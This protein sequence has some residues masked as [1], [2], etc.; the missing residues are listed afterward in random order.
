M[1]FACSLGGPPDFLG[2]AG[3]GFGAAA[4]NSGGVSCTSG[5]FT[6][7]QPAGGVAYGSAVLLP[8]I[9]GSGGGGGGGGTA[10]GGSGGGGGGGALLIAASGTLTVN[11]SILANGGAG[12]AVSGSNV[13]A[14]GGGGAGGGIRLVATTIAGNGTISAAGGAGGSASAASPPPFLA[15]AG[16]QGRVR[17][18][19][20]TMTRT[21]AT[22]P[23]F[24]FDAPGTVFVAGFPA[25]T[26]T[27]VAG[28]AAPANPTGSADI[29]LP[30]STPN[31]VTVAFTTTNVPVGNIVKLT[32][33]PANGAPVVAFSPALTGSTTSATASAQVSLPVGPSVLQ[34]QTTYTIVSSLGDA[35]SR[36]AMGERV[37]QIRLSATLGAASTATL[38]TVSGKAF[39]VPAALLATT[40]Q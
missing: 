20:E 40:L 10:F 35:L 6:Y 34:A 17:L 7:T 4:S 3:G 5:S 16:A 25:L 39:D 19:A 12:G 13:G 32:V 24:S 31:P 37:E 9:G 14:P 26:I 27:S 2:G 11:G 30:A 15:T 23:A 28:V 22:N 38:I 36:Y 8:L 29:T 1:Q 33:T 18:E 21:A